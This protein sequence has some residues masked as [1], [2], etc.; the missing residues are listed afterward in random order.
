MNKRTW[1]IFV[2]ICVAIFGIL[3][4]VSRGQTTDVANIESAKVLA[5][6][7]ESGE[8]ADHVSGKKDSKVILVEYGDFACP[9]CGQAY[10]ILK[11]LSEQYKDKIAFVFR[12]FPLTSMHPNAKAAAAAAEAAGL[13]DKY[14]EMHDKLYEDQNS[15]TNLGVNERT[16]RFISYAQAI[17]VKDIEKLKTDM[18][19]EPV[20]KKIAFDQ[21]L[22]KKV[23]VDG[24][25]GIF[26]NDKK[27]GTET[28]GDKEKFKAAI[29]EALK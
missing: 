5:A 20:N 13:Q 8:I 3:I 26:L 11:E 25:P 19:S 18:S 24:T 27:I 2:V 16:A 21:A 4:A 29:E 12:N 17:G 9:G 15:W 23:G 7:S 28:W 22:G 1:I 10:P 14:W 6:A